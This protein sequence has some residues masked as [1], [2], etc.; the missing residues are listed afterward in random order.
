MTNTNRAFT[1]AIAWNREMLIQAEILQDSF[2]YVEGLARF[3][4][5][6]LAPHSWGV[7]TLTIDQVELASGVLV[8][9][10]MELKTEDG[11]EINFHSDNEYN[12]NLSLDLNNYR[13]YI[14]KCGI[15][16]SLI[17]PAEA[18]GG[19]GPR[20]MENQFRRVSGQFVLDETTE[21]EPLSIPR[22]RPKMELQVYEGKT[23]GLCS[24]PLV[25]I[26]DTD[27]G[28]ELDQ[29][30]APTM[31]LKHNPLIVELCSEIPAM[32]RKKASL[33][34]EKLKCMC[35][36][37]EYLEIMEIKSQ[38][39]CLVSLLPSLEIDLQSPSLHP[40]KLYSSLAHL[41]GN[42]AF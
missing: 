6:E 30:I 24:V 28:F 11:H 33:L 34:V 7:R 41:A 20:R 29:Y 13:E 12:E 1:G 38:I 35:L 14:S 26:K 8:I 21:E 37:K 2:H 22:W 40:G 42:I 36:G 25:K 32:L 27:S 17:I 39:R 5:T 31:A 3:Q 15:V 9:K 10:E 18:R 16:I 4:I 23:R 19:D